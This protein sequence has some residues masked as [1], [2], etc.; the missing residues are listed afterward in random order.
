MKRWIVLI[1]IIIILVIQYLF[2]GIKTKVSRK[3]FQDFRWKS[4]EPK[5]QVILVAYMRSGS[6]FVGNILQYNP[7]V[8]YVFEPLYTLEQ[9]Y[10]SAIKKPIT[11]FHKPPF[12]KG[13]VD[14]EELKN[15]YVSKALSCDF[16][17]LDIDTLTHIHWIRGKME[18]YYECLIGN[19]KFKST[20]QKTR[21]SAPDLKSI[22]RSNILKCL[23]FLYKE[24]DK[25][26]VSLIKLI[27]YKMRS[28]EILLAKY[29]NYKIII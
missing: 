8:F 28:A 4:K 24:C 6:S 5:Q 10:T 25:R 17:N 18:P 15:E 3:Y 1:T 11:F 14:Y 27:R 13:D 16:R 7:D 19:G 12:F 23:H 20:N 2:T 29:P 21:Q 22:S 9:F 26:N